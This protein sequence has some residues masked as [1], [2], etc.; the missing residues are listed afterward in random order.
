MP[1]EEVDGTTIQGYEQWLKDSGLCRNTTSFYIRN[2][3]TI[4]N[5]AVDDL[6]VISSS[7]FKHV[8]TGIDKT[9]KGTPP[10]NH[11]ATERAGLESPN[12]CLELARDMFL[13]SFLYPG[14][15]VHR[16][17]TPTPS[18]LHGA[19]RSFTAVRRPHNSCTSNG[20]LPCRR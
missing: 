1:L 4:Y 11:Q 9:V 14:D 10:G 3:R 19:A 7:P 15:V 17:G 20:N 16:Y 18:N 12:P 5:H 2:L 6:T 13:F 8:Y